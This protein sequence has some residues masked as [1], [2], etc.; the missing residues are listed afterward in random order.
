MIKAVE[1]F[2][3][4]KGVKFISLQPPINIGEIKDQDNQEKN[5]KKNL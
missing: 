2:E 3:P 5:T 4:Q 1:R